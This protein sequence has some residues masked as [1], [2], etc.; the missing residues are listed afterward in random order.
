M[1]EIIEP[2]IEP[3]VP[4]ETDAWITG[5]NCPA[6]LAVL[7]ATTGSLRCA[8]CRRDYPI[9]DGIADLRQGRKDYY[10]N[11]VPRPQMAE[12]TAHAER[13]DWPKAIRR[14]IEGAKHN[15]EWLDNL[16]T[17]GRY[18]WKL[19]LDLP[20]GARVLDLGCGLGNLTKNIAP[21][22]GEV[23][24]LDLTW[25]RLQFARRRFALFNR[26]DRIALVAGGDGKHLPFADASF[27]CVM[28]SGV[29]EW[30]ADDDSAWVGVEGKAARA[31]KML[32]AHFGA[33][34]PRRVQ[35]AFLKEIG[36]VLKPGGQLFVGIENRLSYEYF[37]GLPDHHAGV[38]YASLLPR[39]LATLYTMWR[40]RAPYRTYT[41]AHPGHRRLMADAGFARTRFLGL[42][43][44]YSHLSSILPYDEPGARFDAPRRV[45]W[46]EAIRSSKLFV[47]AYGVIASK[48]A[49]AS[50]SLFERIAQEI[51]Q[52][53]N[54]PLRHVGAPRVTGRAKLIA[55]AK[56][57]AEDVV[58]RIALNDESRRG[59]AANHEALHWLGEDRDA[60]KAPRPIARGM[61]QGVAWFVE[62]GARGEP[63]QRLLQQPG[64]VDHLAG[65]AEVLSVLNPD[66]PGAAAV[67]LEGEGFERWVGEPL[68]RLAPCV[69]D[70]ASIAS[71]RAGL[72]RHLA[73]AQTRVG[74]V[75]GDFNPENFC[76]S[77]GTVTGVV[78][79]EQAS[80]DGLPI[81]DA[82][83]CVE[84]ALR[85]A[86][87]T[88][89][90]ADSVAMLL[91]PERLPAAYRSFLDAQFDRAGCGIG[92]R[93]GF[94]LLYW[95]QHVDKQLVE[96]ACDAHAIESRIKPM[97]RACAAS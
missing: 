91:E 84:G 44:G 41:Y 79:W 23:C 55:H 47:P 2:K 33:T 31:L 3:A 28:L 97:L 81:L 70:D 14:F 86:G 26:D 69:E 95:L 67:A 37:L 78:D 19:F 58:L 42:T 56:L 60:A 12:V 61:T 73:G 51:E 90:V 29:L 88:H 83:N 35:L 59:E 54:A 25:E 27:D 85:V 15:R 92:S 30:V 22:V 36:R 40:A 34:N 13:R 96:L 64:H 4:A 5:L 6:C 24:A 93:R 75:H 39:G 82:I 7:E 10:F 45:G 66:L 53:C 48:S 9:A 18:A 8:A 80:R 71:A 38:R 57:G 50:P 76:W 43:P 87:K 89:S 62:Q 16:V 11:P 94:V 68:R 74:R 21:H 20:P 49:A 32:A 46:K 72:A 1:A 65:V 77:D 52:R 63:M 17:D